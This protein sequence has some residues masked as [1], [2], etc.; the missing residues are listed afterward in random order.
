[1]RHHSTQGGGGGPPICR[2]FVSRTSQNRFLVFALFAPALASRG[3]KRKTRS[4]PECCI[5]SGQQG[6]DPRL[7]PLVMRL[8]VDG[9]WA[10]A[11]ISYQQDYCHES[12]DT[13][14]H[15]SK[16]SGMM[17]SLP[18]Y[19]KSILISHQKTAPLSQPPGG[20]SH[21]GLLP[22]T[23]ASKFRLT[24]AKVHVCQLRLPKA[25]FPSSNNLAS[26][27]LDAWFGRPLSLASN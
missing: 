26:A 13:R 6:A 1:M 24:K 3:T 12:T 21:D 16:N 17:R 20:P 19:G 14:Q 18:V 9:H 10:L 2:S 15:E 25:K 4:F 5:Q 23:E 7:Q 27:P 11:A 8:K 22:P